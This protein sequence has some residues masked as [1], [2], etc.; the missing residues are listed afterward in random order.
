MRELR[1]KITAGSSSM[2]ATKRQ[3]QKKK[4]QKKQTNPKRRN[5]INKNR[6]T[7]T[8]KIQRKRNKKTHKNT[9]KK[10]TKVGNGIDTNAVRIVQVDCDVVL[11]FFV[12]VR[13][14]CGSALC[15]VCCG[16][17]RHMSP[18]RLQ[19]VCLLFAKGGP[20]TNLLHCFSLHHHL[21]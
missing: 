12:C 2:S 5:N 20:Y 3:I 6:K 7:K 13:D 8:P 11:F 17:Q 10:T 14:L 18:L 15:F 19:V 9:N 4:K 21:R 16:Q 1:T